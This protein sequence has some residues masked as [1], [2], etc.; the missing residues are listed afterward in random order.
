[1]NGLRSTIGIYSFHELKLRPFLNTPIRPGIIQLID[2]NH[3]WYPRRVKEDIHIIIFNLIT[4]TGTVKLRF[5]KRGCLQSDNMT[6]DLYHNGPP[7][8]QFLP[9]NA[10]DRNLPTMSKAC[11]T[12]INNNHGGTNSSTLS[13]DAR[14]AV[15]G[16]KV[17]IDV[18]VTIVSQ[19]IKL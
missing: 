6:T 4:S 5:L 18:K 1:M 14:H 9:L 13:P 11:D 10:L 15:C 7:R 2:R 3:R 16:R 19:T 12:P 8:D 17:A